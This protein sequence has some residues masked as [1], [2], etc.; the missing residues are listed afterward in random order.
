MFKQFKDECKQAKKPVIINT[1]S[2]QYLAIEGQGAPG[3][4]MFQGCV[5][6][7]HSMAFTIKMTRKAAGLADVMKSIYPIQDVFPMND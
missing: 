7:L 4:E 5:G 1:T 6:A 3:G 2:A